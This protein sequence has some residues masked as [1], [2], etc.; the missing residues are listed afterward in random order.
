VPLGNHPREGGAFALPVQV[1]LWE[2]GPEA[3]R[4]MGN[5]M[6]D[7]R[8]DAPPDVFY[9]SNGESQE[10]EPTCEVKAIR[11]WCPVRA[12]CVDSSLSELDAL[13]VAGGMTEAKRR[14]LLRAF[15]PASC[16]RR[17]RPELPPGAR[18]PT[19]DRAVDRSEHVVGPLGG[20]VVHTPDEPALQR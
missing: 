7:P 8:R 5:R 15:A 1:W 11:A 12:E 9:A 4:E 20:D 2:D 18:R 13:G 3:R 6:D 19:R 14:K 16:Q 17:V 10:S